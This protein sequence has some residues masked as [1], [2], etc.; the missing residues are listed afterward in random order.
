MPR[1]RQKLL[2]RLGCMACASSA[3]PVA[4]RN[5]LLQ[6][7]VSLGTSSTRQINKIEYDLIDLIMEC[8]K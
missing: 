8:S 6:F 3:D 4:M 7:I 1:N 5:P 2:K